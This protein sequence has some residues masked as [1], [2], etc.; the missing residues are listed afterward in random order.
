[1]FSAAQRSLISLIATSGPVS[2]TDLAAA[3]GLSKAALTTLARALLDE[4]LIREER[5]SNAVSRQGR[6]PVMLAM[7]PDYGYFAGVSIALEEPVIVL[8]D[9]KGEAVARMAIAPS[10]DPDTVAARIADAIPEIAGKAR[11][12]ATRILGI[13]VAISGLVDPHQQTC[14]RSALL[15]WQNVP[16][17]ALIS[18]KSGL[19]AYLDNDANTV[20]T[21]ER[22]FGRA[23]GLDDFVVLTMGDGIGC[24]SI[25]D[26][27]LHRGHHGGAGEVAHTTVEIDG[28]PCKCGK[29]GCL[30]TVASRE[31]VLFAAREAGL[32]IAHVAEIEQR[33]ARN[34]SLAL[35]V[36]HRAGTALGMV[37]MQI[38]HINDP[39]MVLVLDPVGAIGSLTRAAIRQ[40]LTTTVL[41]DMAEGLDLRFADAP[42]DYWSKSAASV[43][44][45]KFFVPA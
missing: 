30:D 24:A 36:I 1:M 27:R 25:I 8:V 40:T 43:A 17:A 16:L 22:L 2:R 34:D 35:Q 28:R 4:G 9:L 14:L 10:G 31:A 3:L 26:G 6:P 12:D 11:I 42:E 32:D 13:G 23:R 5:H 41:P 20:A 39:A 37:I 15:D 7:N 19:P 29:R 18:E 44:A 38:V 45:H 33:A 21:W